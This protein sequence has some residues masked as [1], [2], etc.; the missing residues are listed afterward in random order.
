M[1]LAFGLPALLARLIMLPGD[2]VRLAMLSS[3]PVSEEDFQVLEKT[4]RAVVG[5]FPLN[6]NFNDL[7]LVA[8][9]RGG[10]A[11]GE[12]AKA[13]FAESEGWQRRALTASPADPY[14]WFRLGYL[15]LF[16]DG[17]PSPRTAAAWTQS[18]AVAPYEPELMIPRLQMGMANYA[19]LKPEAKGYLPIL[20]RGSS[21][22]DAEG[23]ARLA[24]A[25][26][27]TGLVEEALV[28]DE[29][30]LKAFRERIAK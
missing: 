8:F 16:A 23:L 14:G 11:D 13:L 15:F 28:G 21:I 17:R 26:R 5:W 3:Q 7:A 29:E 10:Q 9:T 19:F 30:A 18:M 4:R 24:K 22:F 20:I 1:L 12:A 6:A 2:S 25:G 27:F